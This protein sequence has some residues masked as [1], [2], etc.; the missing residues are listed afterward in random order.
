MQIVSV[1]FDVILRY[2]WK[3]CRQ[4]KNGSEFNYTCGAQLLSSPG[5]SQSAG[6][7]WDYFFGESSEMKV[8]SVGHPK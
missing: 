5:Y 6:F 2:L 4:P 7:H 3:L 8:K 1:L